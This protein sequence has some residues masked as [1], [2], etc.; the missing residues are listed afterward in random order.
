MRSA[1]P[2]EHVSP[3]LGG[4]KDHIAPATEN[5]GRASQ[6]DR[7]E[8]GTVGADHED[9]PHCRLRGC[10]HARPEIA[11]GLTPK[12]KAM[13]GAD[14]LEQGIGLV[15]RPP[16]RH[17]AELGA[18]RGVCSTFDQLGLQQSGAL[19]TQYGNESRLGEARHRRL[20][21]DG[22]LDRLMHCHIGAQ[23]FLDRR[24][25]R[26]PTAASTSGPPCAARRAPPNAG[27]K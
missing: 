22:D 8:A 14:L 24:R 11:F 12:R 6:Q 23:A 26:T 3:V 18:R 19:R 15:R 16:Q 13:P 10:E 2:D 17:R 27:R 7:G 1:H 20:G 21:Q 5:V 9:G 25:K 4:Q